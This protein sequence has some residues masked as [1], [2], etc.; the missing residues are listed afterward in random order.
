[1]YYFKIYK[2]LPIYIFLLWHFQFLY[3]AFAFLR[4]YTAFSFSRF[5]IS[6]SGLILQ[7]AVQISFAPYLLL[8]FDYILSQ[9]S[10]MCKYDIY[11]N[12]AWFSANHKSGTIFYFLYLIA[13]Y[14]WLV[15]PLVKL[16]PNMVCLPG[17]YLMKPD[18]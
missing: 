15:K 10:I 13:G 8:Y 17:L 7:K 4:C 16:L 5:Y 12:D 18:L 14:L 3:Y 1:M 9:S 11:L 6:N 2:L